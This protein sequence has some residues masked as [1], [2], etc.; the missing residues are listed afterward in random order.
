MSAKLKLSPRAR[1]D[2]GEIWDYTE[3]RWGA[4]QAELYIKRIWQ[5][6]EA[7]AHDPAKGRSCDA[8]RQ[9]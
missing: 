1:R 7:V 4:D 5:A 6:I 8:I 9:G 2:L 3:E